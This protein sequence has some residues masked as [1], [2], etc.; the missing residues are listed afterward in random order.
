MPKSARSLARLIQ[1]AFEEV[2]RA[3]RACCVRVSMFS[4]MKS[5]VRSF[6]TC[7]AVAGLGAA[8]EI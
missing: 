7:C 1:L 4:W 2:C 6:T 8:Y 5:E 3:R